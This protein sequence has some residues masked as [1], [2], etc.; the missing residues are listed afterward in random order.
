MQIA[1]RGFLISKV[2]EALNE[3]FAEDKPSYY[4]LWEVPLS[5]NFI[6]QGM[7]KDRKF[8]EKIKPSTIIKILDKGY[9]SLQDFL[10]NYQTYHPRLDLQGE[11]TAFVNFLEQETGFKFF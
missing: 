2:A 4:E 11:D 1:I 9:L 7:I 3:L 6:K 8:L 5:S 10:N